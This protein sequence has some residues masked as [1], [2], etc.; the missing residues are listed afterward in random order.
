MTK[1]IIIDE[2]KL[3]GFCR[4]KPTLKDC[5][6]FFECSEDTIERRCKDLGSKTF[7]EFREKNM[8]HTRHSLQQ[9]A[10]RQ[11]LKGNSTMLI[12]CLKNLC[13]WADKMETKTEIS[14]SDSELDEAIKQLKED[15][16]RIKDED[17]RL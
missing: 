13:G 17:P 10:I 12:F 2:A 9:E 4:L 16:R 7:A 14:M 15:E 1:Q 8:V 5:A 3:K 11:A 6:A